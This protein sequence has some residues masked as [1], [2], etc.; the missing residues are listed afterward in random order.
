MRILLA[1]GP[2][3]IERQS[4]IVIIYHEFV[5]KVLMKKK[6]KINAAY[7]MTEYYTT[8]RES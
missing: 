1:V 8:K 3:S 6:L 5:L 7:W 4:Y 2:P